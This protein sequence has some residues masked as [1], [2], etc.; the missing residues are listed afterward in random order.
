MTHDNETVLDRVRRR[1]VGDCLAE[2]GQ[3]LVVAVSGGADSCCLLHALHRL[4]AELGLRLHVAHLDH[5]LRGAESEA[6]AAYVDA[7]AAE[8]GL[9]VTVA[10]RDVRAFAATHRI[11]I[12]HAAR[13]VRYAF[14]AEVAVDIG[15]AAVAVGHTADDQVET[16][17]LHVVRGAGLAG[18]RGMAPAQQWRSRLSGAT[19]RVVRPL[20]GVWRRET[21]A[22]CAAVGLA[23]RRD[24]SNADTAALRNRVRLELLPLLRRL[25]PAIDTALLRLAA[26][27]AANYAAIAAEVERLWPRLASETD[28]GIALDSIEL[29]RLAA[30]LQ[31][32]VLRHAVYRLQGDTE[33]LTSAHLTAL[34]ALTQK[35]VGK[36]AHLPRGLVATIGYGAL[37]LSRRPPSD[38]APRLDGEWPLAVP[39]ETAIPGW[40]FRA[41][42]AAAAE[43]PRDPWCVY[44]DFDQ[45][46]GD[47]VVRGRRPG[48]RF[49][50]LGM[51]GAKKLHDFFVDAKVPR[52]ERDAAPLVVAERGIAWVVGHRIDHR[53]RVT[54][55]TR[56]V[57]RLAAE[58]LV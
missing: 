28:G 20:L 29:G 58:R 9:P 30:P 25:N 3:T 31:V 42:F 16:V 27:A 36:R 15:A 37:T 49:Q 50:P 53:V 23:P 6:D 13:E 38:E 54:A 2:P 22:Y 44:L 51:A 34:V 48:D 4:R 52:G 19:V 14:L 46:G 41:S 40:R 26:A 8:L 43:P 18:L 56:S 10:R 45:L 1:L 12:E 33:D 57:L 47:I 55:T 24:S 39:G 32:E 35:P 11:G 21:V 7:L 5:Q 17:L